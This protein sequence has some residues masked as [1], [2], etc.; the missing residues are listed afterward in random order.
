MWARPGK[1]VH[2][3]VRGRDVGL[4]QADAGRAVGEDG[5]CASDSTE[6]PRPL[7]QDYDSEAIAKT[8]TTLA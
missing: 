5:P 8:L 7:Y 6:M 1:R 2:V 3:A 4:R